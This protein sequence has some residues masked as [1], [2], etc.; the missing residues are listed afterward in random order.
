MR[1][2]QPAPKPPG[3]PAML[4]ERAQDHLRFIRKTM[5]EAASFTGVSG[6]GEMLVGLTALVAAPWAASRTTEGGWLAVWIGEALLAVLLTV[7]AMSW[8]AKHTGVPLLGRPG[9]R[10]AL[11]LTPPLAAG[12]VLTIFLFRAGAID[13]LPGLWL[14]LY[15][16][17]VATGGAASS[18]RVVPAMGVS[19]MLLGAVALGLPPSGRDLI[20]AA[21]FGGL[22]LLFGAVIWSRHGG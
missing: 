22:H 1:T 21:G 13:L 18:A 19:F 11:G 4:G 7:G 17:G 2:I 10:F 6:W 15:G 5:E 9:R 14:L 3:S 8:K 16:T 20:L 12:A